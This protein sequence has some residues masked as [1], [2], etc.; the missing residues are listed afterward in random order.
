MRGFVLFLFAQPPIRK[1][2]K[3]GMF[4]VG[5]VVASTLSKLALRMAAVHGATSQTAKSVMADSTLVMASILELGQSSVPKHNIDQ[6]SYERIV[7]CM[8]A[9]GDPAVGG[10]MRDILLSGTREAYSALARAAREE[11]A[12]EGETKTPAVTAHV[13]QL[14]SVRQLRPRDGGELATLGLDDEADIIKGRALVRLCWPFGVR[15][16]EL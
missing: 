14:I 6:D 2:L 12:A 3:S 7:S 5:A 4:F 13:D 8:R 16:L 9:I 11:V 15:P 1:L 10:A